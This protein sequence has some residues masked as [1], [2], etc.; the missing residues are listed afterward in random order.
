MR[1]TKRG[2]GSG[3]TGMTNQHYAFLVC[4]LMLSKKRIVRRKETTLEDISPT[5]E[6]STS[7]I[8]RT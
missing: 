3:G 2:K 7:H 1:E 8:V 5:F 4:H 6:L